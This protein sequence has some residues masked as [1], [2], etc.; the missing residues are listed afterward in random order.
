MITTLQKLL[1]IHQAKEFPE[2]QIN[3]NNCFD[4]FVSASIGRNHEPLTT[5]Q[6]IQL[7]EAFRNHVD[8]VYALSGYARATAKDKEQKV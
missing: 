6:S 7:H 2:A 5:A 8:A 1:V 3:Y 4:S